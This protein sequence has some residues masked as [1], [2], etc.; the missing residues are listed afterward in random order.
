MLKNKVIA[1]LFLC[2][3]LA[4]GANALIQ[5]GAVESR[6]ADAAMNGDLTVVRN[7]L[8]QGADVNAAQGD[9]MTALHWAVFKDNADMVKTLVSAGANVSATTRINGLTPLFFAAQNGQAA[10]I[11]I[12][13]KAGAKPNTPL[14][15]GV[16]PLMIAAKAGN[17]DAVK[18]LLDNGADANAKENARGETALMFAAAANRA[19][20]I[21]V[22]LQ[23]GANASLATKVIDIA[24]K[25]AAARGQAAQVAAAQPPQPGQPA[26]A[27]RGRGG[28][29][30][31]GGNMDEERPPLVDFQG[32]MTPLLFAA[33]QGHLEAAKALLEGGANVNEVSPGDKTSPLLIASV[34]GKYDLAMYLLDKGA[35]P[36][37]ASTAGATPLYTAVNVKWAP[38][39]DYPQPDTRQ[40]RTSYL[41][42]MTALLDRGAD[43]NARLK[44][45][46]WYS[47]YNFDLSQANAAGAT[48]FWRASQASDVPAMKLLLERGANPFIKTAEAVS[49]LHV[50]AGAGVHGN[51]EITATG[52]WF[53]GVKFLVD[54]VHADVNEGDGKGLTPLHHA[55]A[56]GDNEMILF[57]VSRGADPTKV[58]KTGQTVSDLANGPRQRIQPFQDTLALLSLLGSKNSHKCVSC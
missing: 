13:L 34:N 7:L 54:V 2:L 58:S 43:P 35:D 31:G 50:A 6:V 18:V 48:P 36:T 39:S 15:T 41:E 12:L 47:S 46:L 23:S 29:G 57:L 40:Q 28:R 33:R 9:G 30:N 20:A 25:N 56:R 16:T 19:A 24:A 27:G 26:A 37:L 21:K 44:L 11:D 22:L 53:P 51:D 55:A 10:V 14:A 5:A 45:E 42:L 3:V 8:K 49:P 38:K 32:G 17:P 52:S 4:L 1:A